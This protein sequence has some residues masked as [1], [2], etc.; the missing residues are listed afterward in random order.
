MQ[1]SFFQKRLFLGLHHFFKRLWALV[2]TVVNEFLKDECLNL[3]AQIS[4]FALFSIFPLFLGVILLTSLFFNDPGARATLLRQLTEIFPSNTVDVAGT[5]NETLQNS[6]RFGPI[7]FLLFLLGLIWGGTGLFDAL[8]NAINKAWQVPGGQP[9]TFFESLLMRFVLFGI[10]LILL[11]GSLGVS[12]TFSV[13]KNFAE[14]NEQLKTYLKDTP[15]WDWLAVAIPWILNFITFM[16]IYRIIPQRKV[17]FGDVW[18]GA[19]LATVLLELVKIGFAF[20]VTQI[21]HYSATYGSLSGVI[22]FIFW[23]YLIAVV[24]LLGGETSSVYAEMRGDK[25]PDKLARQGHRAEAPPVTLSDEDDDL[26]EYGYSREGLI[27]SYTA[28]LTEE[29]VL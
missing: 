14:T 13:V 20:Y 23:L 21:V 4:Y 5:V 11:I 19:A 22:V 7:L 6:Q 25:S 15:I 17:K 16:I 1:G 3:A 8:S 26:L 28:P 18:P 9:R 29:K 2:R 24:V 10:F 12:I 27:C